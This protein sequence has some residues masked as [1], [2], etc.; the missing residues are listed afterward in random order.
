MSPFDTIPDN[1][2][3]RYVSNLDPT[4]QMLLYFGMWCVVAGAFIGILYL[5]G[6]VFSTGGGYED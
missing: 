2:V 3:V 1:P 5:I 6:R 4:P